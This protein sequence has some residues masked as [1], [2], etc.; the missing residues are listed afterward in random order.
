[1]ALFSFGN[2]KLP[3]HTAIFNMSSATDCESNRKGL[4]Q[5]VN[6]KKC[7]ALKAER[8]YKAVLPYRKR[9]NIFWKNCTAEEFVEQFEKEK[10]RKK[11]KYLRLNEAGD[12][13]TQKCVE[14]ANKIAEILLQKHKI[15]TYCYTARKD[16]DFSNRTQLTVNGSGFKVDNMFAV[17]YTDNRM[18]QARRTKGE[19]VCIGDCAKCIMCTKSLGLDIYVRE[20]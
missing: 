7:Y 13:V 19:A 18:T 16:L 12:F 2:R 4:C 10:G 1:M 6:V 5:L 8:M 3:K 15:R 20:H 17:A 11:I 9:Q 14:K